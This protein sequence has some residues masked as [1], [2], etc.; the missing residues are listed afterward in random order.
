MH[1]A[2]QAGRVIYFSSG[3]DPV[4]QTEPPALC[5]K[6]TAGEDPCQDVNQPEQVYNTDNLDPIVAPNIDL[7]IIWYTPF[8]TLT[9]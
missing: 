4:M 2:G 6:R 8:V 7:N 1:K 5:H 3:A 9:I